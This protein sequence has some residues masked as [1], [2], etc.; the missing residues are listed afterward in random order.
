[1]EGFPECQ[2]LYSLFYNINKAGSRLVIRPKHAQVSV[3]NPWAFYHLGYKLHKKERLLDNNF[4]EKNPAV[5]LV[6]VYSV[7]PS[8]LWVLALTFHAILFEILSVDLYT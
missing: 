5:S 1:M 3:Y 4:E 8:W 2:F 6:R 7:L